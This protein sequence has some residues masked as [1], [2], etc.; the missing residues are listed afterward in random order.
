[1]ASLI[2]PAFLP[3]I[4]LMTSRLLNF[5]RINPVKDDALEIVEYAYKEY[6]VK[7]IKTVP[8]AM[9]YHFYDSRAYPVYEF[10]Q[11][12]NTDMLEAF[13]F[14][15]IK[16][17]EESIAFLNKCGDVAKFYSFNPD[18]SILIFVYYYDIFIP[19]LYRY[20][21]D[22]KR[23]LNIILKEL[24]DFSAQVEEIK[25]IYQK[26]REFYESFAQ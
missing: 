12:K 6:H 24:K 18:N 13:L 14:K 16:N 5:I 7:G 21:K 26:R 15:G 23:Y 17:K 10:I 11:D 9:E 25:K 2:W 8:P 19:K 4:S 20:L 1:M 22:D 3:G